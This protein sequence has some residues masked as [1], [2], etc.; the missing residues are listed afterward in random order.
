MRL[1]KYLINEEGGEGGT[2][3][4][5]TGPGTMTGNVEKFYDKI[6]GEPVRRKKLRKNKPK[7]SKFGSLLG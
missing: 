6:K 7:L 5:S 2:A 3:S 4:T 1:K